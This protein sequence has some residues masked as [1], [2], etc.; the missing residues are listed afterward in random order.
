MPHS[1][2]ALI[3]AMCGIA[4]WGVNVLVPLA[5][6]LRTTLNVVAAIAI[7]LWLARVLGGGEDVRNI[8]L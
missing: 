1:D 2:I 4:L 7:C 5:K 8:R 3:L 6:P